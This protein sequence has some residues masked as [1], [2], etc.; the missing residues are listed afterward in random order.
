MSLKIITNPRPNH[1]YYRIK[2]G[3]RF[4]G[5]KYAE[6]Q[7]ASHPYGKNYKI[8]CT[9]CDAT[10]NKTQAVLCDQKI[11]IEWQHGE[12]VFERIYNELF[13]P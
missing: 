4:C 13:V 8:A 2:Y 5:N 10:L 7:N 12:P 1:D 11:E 9:K 3:C 6:Q